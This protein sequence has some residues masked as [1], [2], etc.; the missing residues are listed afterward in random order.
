MNTESTCK[1]VPNAKHKGH[2]RKREGVSEDGRRRHRE[3]TWR[4]G[5]NGWFL[6]RDVTSHNIAFTSLSIQTKVECVCVSHFSRFFISTTG[7]GVLT[8]YCMFA[9]VFYIILHRYHCDCTRRRST[10]PACTD[11]PAAHSTTAVHLSTV[12][13]STCTYIFAYASLHL[14]FFIFIPCSTFYYPIC[15]FRI[16]VFLLCFFTSYLN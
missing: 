5:G 6:Y 1:T 11:R 15:F 4:C 13:M 8:S 16:F 9:S 10:L 12:D 7:E 14:T 3:Y 2:M